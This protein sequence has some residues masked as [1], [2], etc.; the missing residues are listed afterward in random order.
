MILESIVTTVDQ[1]GR[2]NIAPM[3]PSVDEGF[4]TAMVDELVF[5]LRPFSSSQTYKNL[6]ANRTA[7]IHVTDNVDLFSRAVTGGFENGEDVRSMVDCLDDQFYV[8]RDCHRWFAVEIDESITVSNDREKSGEAIRHRFVCHVKQTGIV[9]PFFG[10]N[11]AKHAVVEAAILAS[12]I[13][14]LPIE[15]IRIELESLQP[16]VDKTG[17]KTEMDAFDRIKRLVDGV[18]PNRSLLQSNASS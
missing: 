10:F 7:T 11:R 12:R 18:T 13:G 15:Q 4:Q 1:R 8:L 6:V 16:L 9:R 3:G 5:E 2:V 14:I 17:G